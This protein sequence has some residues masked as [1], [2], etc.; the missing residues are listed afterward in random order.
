M[1]TGD[2]FSKSEDQMDF[3]RELG[4]PKKIAVFF[5]V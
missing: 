3:S 4:C 5:N 2:Q 1:K